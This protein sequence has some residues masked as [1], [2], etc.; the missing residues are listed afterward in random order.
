MRIGISCLWVLIRNVSGNNSVSKRL[1]QDR[2]AA[3]M[4]TLAA[5]QE[6]ASHF[7]RQVSGGISDECVGDKSEGVVDGFSR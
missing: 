3:L 1:L 6:A 2:K 4:M 7:G 5:R